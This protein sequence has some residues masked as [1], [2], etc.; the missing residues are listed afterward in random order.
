MRFGGRSSSLNSWLNQLGYICESNCEGKRDKSYFSIA[1]YL[2]YLPFE[3]RLEAVPTTNVVDT[4]AARR[5]HSSAPI[6]DE[7]TAP[8]LALRKGH[9]QH[10]SPS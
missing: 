8:G 6:T 1:A 9:S 4:A 3:A 7:A 5:L 10:P 2:Q